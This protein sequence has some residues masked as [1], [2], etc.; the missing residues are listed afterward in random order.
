M[1]TEKLI[2]ALN[3]L[4][5]R[6]HDAKKGYT[7]AGNDVSDGLLRKWLFDNAEK[8]DAYIKE[9]HNTIRSLAGT[10]DHGT[11]FLGD[12]HRTWIDF[13][14]N[15]TDGDTAVMNECIRGEERALEDYEKVLNELTMTTA[16]REI[17]LRQ[18][19]NI[20]D[21]LQSLKAIKQSLV[22]A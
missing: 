21:A 2:G 19:R 5:T 20:E 11:S 22:A 8:R 10:P 7:E 1:N 13:R 6:N 16:I 17:L 18:R 12:M 15:L 9:L 14:A 3:D 4:L